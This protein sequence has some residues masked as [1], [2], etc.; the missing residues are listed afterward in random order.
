MRS[1]LKQNSVALFMMSAFRLQGKKYFKIL[2]E[3][4]AGTSWSTSASHSA[5]LRNASRSDIWQHTSE[6]SAT[7]LLVLSLSPTHTVQYLRWII[8]QIQEQT[9]IVHGPIFLEV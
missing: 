5:L 9:H 8:G 3:P 6:A 4:A 1:M 7:S 2:R